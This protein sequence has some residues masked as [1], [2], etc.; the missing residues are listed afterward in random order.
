MTREQIVRISCWLL[1]G[2]LVIGAIRGDL[3][4]PLDRE[5]ANDAA[6]QQR[7]LERLER[8]VPGALARLGER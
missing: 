5:F 1:F 4:Q 2:A 7:H 8:H 6:Q 3:W